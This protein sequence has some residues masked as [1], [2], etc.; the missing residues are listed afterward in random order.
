MVACDALIRR[1]A[2]LTP[3]SSI[4][5]IGLRLSC[6]LLLAVA[7]PAPLAQEAYDLVIAGGFVVDG[8]GKIY[9]KY[10]GPLNGDILEN[11]ILPV[12]EKLK[13]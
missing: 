12:I 6:T 13:R 7:A 5:R 3:C 11:Q 8:T 10:V 4:M 9:F 2:R 1:S